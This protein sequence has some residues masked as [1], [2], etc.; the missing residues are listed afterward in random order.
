MREN[1]RSSTRAIVW[2][3][4]VLA[5]PGAPTM[6]LLPPT[7][8]VISAWA[9]T[10]SWPTMIFFSSV[11]ISCRPAFMRSASAMS[12]G[13]SRSTTSLTI[14]FT[15]PPESGSGRESV[16]EKGLPTPLRFCHAF[17]G[18][19]L[20]RLA[21]DLQRELLQF[22]RVLRRLHA[23]LQQT[24]VLHAPLHLAALHD[25]R[26]HLRIHRQRSRIGRPEREH[27]R[28]PPVLGRPRRR[29]RPF[30]VAIVIEQ[31]VLDGEQPL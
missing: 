30:L 18:S 21:C 20:A 11:T 2:I 15:G 5:R 25:E 29:L 22:A 16:L 14:G 7:K 28:H 12:S 19:D 24:E 1:L 31:R 13:D 4:S 10:S 23:V 3:S 8:S 27:R 6:R 17:R 9:I 26:G